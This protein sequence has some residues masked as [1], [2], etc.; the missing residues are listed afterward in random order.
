MHKGGREGAQLPLARGESEEGRKTG[1]RR[2]A[3]AAAE[4]LT[5]RGKINRPIIT[6]FATGVAASGQNLGRWR[7]QG[8]TLQREKWY[9]VSS[10]KTRWVCQIEQRGLLVTF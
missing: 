3:A 8:A 7:A 9:R 2:V 6:R 4:E 1:G 10:W 5:K